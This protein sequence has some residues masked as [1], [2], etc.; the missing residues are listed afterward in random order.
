MY[1]NRTELCEPFPLYIRDAALTERTTHRRTQKMSD[2]FMV[3]K[4]MFLPLKK[5]FIVRV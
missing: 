5:N 4:V 2:D 1:N 3:M